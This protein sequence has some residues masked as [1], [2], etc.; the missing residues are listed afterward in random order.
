MMPPFSMLI[1]SMA[2]WYTWKLFLWTVKSI[3]NRI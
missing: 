2:L 1:L 3:L